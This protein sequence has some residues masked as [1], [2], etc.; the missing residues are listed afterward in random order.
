[1]QQEPRQECEDL[2]REFGDCLVVSKT[3]HT[4][5]VHTASKLHDSS[6]QGTVVATFLPAL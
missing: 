6:A 2:P 1:M 4:S 5:F 3:G